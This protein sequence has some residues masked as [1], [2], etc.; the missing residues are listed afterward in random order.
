M[1][2]EHVFAEGRGSMLLGPVNSTYPLLHAEYPRYI[3]NL[4]HIM[5]GALPR[6]TQGGLCVRDAKGN[7]ALKVCHRFYEVRL[8]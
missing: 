2:V 3:T 8:P 5:K 6:C 1:G 7:T 4:D